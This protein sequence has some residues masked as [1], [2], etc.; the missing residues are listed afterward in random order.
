MEKFIVFEIIDEKDFDEC[1]KDLLDSGFNWSNESKWILSR[2]NKQR[3]IAICIQSVRS[4][5]GDYKF[6]GI[7]TISKHDSKN[8]SY[9]VTPPYNKSILE[10]FIKCN[11]DVFDLEKFK[12]LVK[13]YTEANKLGLI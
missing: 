4:S 13:P 5:G 8:Y 1:Q 9:F 2:L 7:Y 12:E 10:S 6:N 3:N 11:S